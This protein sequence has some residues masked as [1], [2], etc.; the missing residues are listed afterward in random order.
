M[1]L[2]PTILP[3]SI[4]APAQTGRQPAPAR[5]QFLGTRTVRH[6]IAAT[7]ALSAAARGNLEV[8]HLDPRLPSPAK[9]GSFS[10]L[11]IRI[12]FV[13]TATGLIGDAV[14]IARE[15]AIPLRRLAARNVD[16]WA[17]N[18]GDV[19]SAAGR[20][21]AVRLGP[22]SGCDVPAPD[23]PHGNSEE[24]VQEMLAALRAGQGVEL[25]PHAGR[26]RRQPRPGSGRV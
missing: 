6:V 5:G 9:R 18:L 1:D 17:Q 21:V 24:I 8:S 11:P 7:V 23:H 22:P 12:A 19:V 3:P 15:A 4:G 26:R 13:A 16:D 20:S 25:Q 14:V 10:V 2:D